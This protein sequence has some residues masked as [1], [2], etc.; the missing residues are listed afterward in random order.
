MFRDAFKAFLEL[1]ENEAIL[2]AEGADKASTL[3]ASR[4]LYALLDWLIAWFLGSVVIWMDINGYSKTEIYPIT[5]VIDLL[6][7]YF[8][9]FLS[10]L[11]G[12]DITLAN[13]LRRAADVMFN[14]GVSGKIFGW[15]LLIGNSIKAIIWEGPEVIC[16]MFKKEL[17][18][19]IKFHMSMLILSLGQAVF[20]TWLYTV[21][22]KMLKPFLPSGSGFFH[23]IAMAI[24]IFAIFVT[25]SVVIKK[26]VKLVTLLI[27]KF[28]T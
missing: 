2:S 3:T 25:I 8:F 1:K 18:T 14:N 16:F 26:I 21:G 9:Y 22:Y 4:T 7:S 17:N 20:G 19:R 10:D 15:A 13:S 6:A 24:I 23:V 5:L 27:R 12:Y 28:R 11:S